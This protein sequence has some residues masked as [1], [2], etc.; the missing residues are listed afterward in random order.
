MLRWLFFLI[1][2]SYQDS[3]K[4][5]TFRGMCVLQSV[6]IC[7]NFLHLV[8]ARNFLEVFSRLL[9]FVSRAP[10]TPGIILP[11]M[12]HILCVINMKS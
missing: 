12:F 8:S 1:S 9:Q 6:T 10:I 7:V 11:L 5:N 3:K 4:S 2:E